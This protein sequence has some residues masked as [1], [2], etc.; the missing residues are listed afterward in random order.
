MFARAFQ[1][2]ARQQY[3]GLRPYRPYLLTIA[4]NLRVDQLR[5][6]GR[7]LLLLDDCA[8]P[9]IDALI[10]RDLPMPDLIEHDFER[11]QLQRATRDFV[12]IQDE[13]TQRFV[14]M[15]YEQELSQADVARELGI[16]RRR[17][18]TLESRV[19]SGLAR[20]LRSLGLRS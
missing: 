6:Q 14:A 19:Q 1:E 16:T 10:E 18:R 8:A 3:D 2:R 17:A 20:H 13:E 9:D 11:Q 7:E 5:R 4:K 12:A 15:R